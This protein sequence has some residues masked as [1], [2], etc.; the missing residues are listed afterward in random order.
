MFD[1][2]HAHRLHVDDA[3]AAHDGQHGAGDVLAA[4]LLVDDVLNF[5]G[6]CRIESGL[7]RRCAAPDEERKTKEN[8]A[9]GH[10][11]L[12]APT[13]QLF[14]VAAWPHSISSTKTK[15]CSSSTS[16]PASSCSV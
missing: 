12:Y 10:P 11:P 9:A 14:R 4:H 2:A 6:C 15:R 7:R 13:Q 16:R 3:V 5:G 8:E 1:V